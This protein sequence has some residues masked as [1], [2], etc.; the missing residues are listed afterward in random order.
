VK[1]HIRNIMRKIKA[2]NRTEVAILT[3]D[4]FN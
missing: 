1:I 3:K 4:L 2:R